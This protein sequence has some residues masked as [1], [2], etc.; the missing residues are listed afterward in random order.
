M[1]VRRLHTVIVDE[2]QHSDAVLVALDQEPQAIGGAIREYVTC[3][4]RVNN[5]ILTCLQKV[6]SLD[7]FT[8]DK[9]VS[10]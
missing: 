4:Y 8:G 6:F 5:H 9:T 3:C 7:G 10:K 1:E 2:E